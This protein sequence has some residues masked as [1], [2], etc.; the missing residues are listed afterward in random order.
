MKYLKYMLVSVET[1]PESCE[2]RCLLTIE[3]AAF[4][5]LVS[6]CWE[7]YV[8]QQIDHYFTS[9]D[10]GQT[11]PSITLVRFLLSNL[12]I[13]VVKGCGHSVDEMYGPLESHFFGSP[14]YCLELCEFSMEV[15]TSWKFLEA[16]VWKVW[17]VFNLHYCFFSFRQFFLLIFLIFT[18]FRP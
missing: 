18:A 6:S 2:Y 14:L 5:T 3:M 4:I 10:F 7:K 9:L 1:L 16:R 11:I 17:K 8:H 13:D 12:K 15:T